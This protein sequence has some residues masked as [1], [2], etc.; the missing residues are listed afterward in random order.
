MEVGNPRDKCEKVYSLIQVLMK[1]LKS[2]FAEQGDR[3][4]RSGKQLCCHVGNV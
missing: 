1:Q 2:M 4:L 3:E